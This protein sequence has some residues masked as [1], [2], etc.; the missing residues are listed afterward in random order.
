MTKPIAF[1]VFQENF[2]KPTMR[3]LMR[4]ALSTQGFVASLSLPLSSLFFTFCKLV[5][6]LVQSM[7]N[8]LML[9]NFTLESVIALFLKTAY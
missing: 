6:H 3:N 2:T 7:L 4:L 8:L 9:G 5:V 1:G